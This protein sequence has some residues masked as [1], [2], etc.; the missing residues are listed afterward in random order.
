MNNSG[1]GFYAHESLV[2]NKRQKS[3]SGV[4]KTRMANKTSNC[5]PH[6]FEKE[7]WE[8]YVFAFRDSDKIGTKMLS[9][10]AKKTGLTPKDL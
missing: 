9:R 5:F 2:I 7:G 3:V 6:N 10:I 8:D 1:Q 4:R